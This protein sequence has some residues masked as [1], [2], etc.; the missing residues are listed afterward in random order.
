MHCYLPRQRHLSHPPPPLLL[1][2]LRAAVRSFQRQVPGV[3][4]EAG[5]TGVP[6]PTTTTTGAVRALTLGRPW[7][8]RVLDRVSG[9]KHTYKG[10][11]AKMHACHWFTASM[12]SGSQ[13]F[14]SVH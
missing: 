2:A 11:L 4:S 1:H 14:A 3:V 8:V 7:L 6:R 12:A 10:A 5:R 13:R 9:R